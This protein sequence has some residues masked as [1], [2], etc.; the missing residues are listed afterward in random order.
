V[1]GTDG[2]AYCGVQARCSFEVS[3]EPSVDFVS[4]LKVAVALLVKEEASRRAL[5]LQGLMEEILDALPAFGIHGQR[6]ISEPIL[7]AVSGLLTN[8]RLSK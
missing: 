4:K 6:S 5:A 7:R 1:E 2:A 8:L 3:R